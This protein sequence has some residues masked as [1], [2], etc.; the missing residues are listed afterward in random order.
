MLQPVW[1]RIMARVGTAIVL[2]AV[3]V[4]A[5]GSFSSVAMSALQTSVPSSQPPVLTQAVH[6]AAAANGG[7]LNGWTDT[8]DA[9]TTTLVGQARRESLALNNGVRQLRAQ[10][11]K[12]TPGSFTYQLVL[13]SLLLTA[14]ER[15]SWD[16]TWRQIGRPGMNQVQVQTTL[17]SLQSLYVQANT[18][19]ITVQS[20]EIASSSIFSYSP[21][22]F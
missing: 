9:I 14:A 19:L 7:A 8:Q 11:A 2:G 10:L 4:I 18:S 6:P 15:D 22:A 3:P 13:Q 16:G 17:I 20:Q 12:L 5:L 21:P 1:Q